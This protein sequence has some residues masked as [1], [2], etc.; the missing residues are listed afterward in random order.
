MAA[1]RFP[2]KITDY[3]GFEIY[4]NPLKKEYYSSHCEHTYR[5]KEI[6]KV[7]EWIETYKR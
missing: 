2:R 5:S 1:D 3:K 4:Y 6:K 7:E